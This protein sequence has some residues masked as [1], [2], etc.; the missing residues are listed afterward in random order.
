MPASAALSTALTGI[1]LE[2]AATGVLE[3]ESSLGVELGCSVAWVEVPV[4]VPLPS[5]CA[6]AVATELPVGQMVSTSP[7]TPL[8]LSLRP[9]RPTP[10]ACEVPGAFATSNIELSCVPSVEIALGKALHLEP[11]QCCVEAT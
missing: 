11:S 5:S 4:G 10:H 2:V 9:E 7:M 8:R 1:P 6:A 3:P